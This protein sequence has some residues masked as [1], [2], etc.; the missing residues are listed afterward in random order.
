MAGAY[1]HFPHMRAD[2]DALAILDPPMSG[3]E[4]THVIAQA[5][6]AGPAALYRGVGPVRLAVELQCIPPRL[7]ASGGHQGPTREI[8]QSRDP[9][10]RVIPARQP[11]CHADVVR[12]HVR[13]QHAQ[14]RPVQRRLAHQPLPHCDGFFG[15][16][17][18]IPHRP[19]VTAF[20][21][22]MRIH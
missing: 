11:S 4:R 7:S 8:L 20:D 2:A 5:A 6:E 14:Q 22:G 9:Q 16:R 21:S 12:M 18:G 3:G 19:A 1:D 15:A 13:D 17:A 10:P